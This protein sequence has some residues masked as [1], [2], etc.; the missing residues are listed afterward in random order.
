MKIK[1]SK[2]LTAV[3][4]LF[5][6]ALWG[7]STPI[8]KLGYRYTDASHLPSLFLWV[9]LQFVMAG[10]LT[11]GIYSA[12]SKRLVYP[13]KKSMKGIVLIAALQ[14]ALQYSLTYLGLQYTTSVKGAILKSTDVFL[15]ALIAG[16]IFKMQKF[17]VRKVLACI[18]GF[19]G[20]IVMNL[21]GLH[22]NIR[23]LGDGLVLLGILSYSFAAVITRLFAQEE[24]PIMLS[25]Y[26][27]A[28]GGSFLLI[29]GIVSG[30]AM[31][32]WGMLPVMLGLSAIYAV[33]YTLWTVL[34]KYN[35]PSD[36]SIY[37]FMTPVFGVIFSAILLTEASGVA[38]PS[39]MMALVLVCAGIVMWSYEKKNI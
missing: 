23:P 31:D 37:S 5:C 1:N 39:L 6:C 11:V 26:Q 35:T 15:V 9:G 33:S 3:T 10:V 29:A 4:A 8:V 7:V 20:I 14:T 30:G 38:L 12:V 25:G 2:I 19:A 28:L 16:L 27:M 32:F 17:T 21:D 34:L 18:I 36:I 13:K 22:F 24:D